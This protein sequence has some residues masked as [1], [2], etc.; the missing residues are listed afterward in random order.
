VADV[1]QTLGAAKPSSAPR[2]AAK[3]PTQGPRPLGELRDDELRLESPKDLR[4]LLAQPL[5]ADAAVRVALTRS[6]P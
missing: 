1:T 6:R 3:T 4:S 5:D 2:D